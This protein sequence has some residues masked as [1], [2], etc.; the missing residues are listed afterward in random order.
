MRR[1]EGRLQALVEAG[2]LEIADVELAA[3]QFSELCK[4]GIFHR[5][6]FCAES[7]PTAEE[8]HRTI[9]GAVDVFMAAYGPKR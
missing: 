8:I 9:R 4:A 1:L 6:I 5:A 3:R 7:H 2:E